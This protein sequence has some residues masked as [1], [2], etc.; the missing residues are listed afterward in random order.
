MFIYI[1]HIYEFRSILYRFHLITVQLI[2]M[3]KKREFILL[4]LGVILT[5]IGDVIGTYH[6]TPNLA[7]E[8]N[9]MVSLLGMG[10]LYILTA[11]VTVI[12]FSATINYYSLFK[13][14]PEE[15][16][17]RDLNLNNYLSTLYF[18]KATEWKWWYA[19]VKRPVGKNQEIYAYGWI[20]PRILIHVGI[21]I[22]IFHCLLAF[23]PGYISIH[24]YFVVPMY[25]LIVLCIPYNFLSYLKFRYKRYLLF[26]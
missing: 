9:P 2:R 15:V 26:R 3:H 20:I 11:Q 16:L 5:R 8:A 7:S 23:V 10:W 13:V 6:Y 24:K 25:L 1:L 14:M 21:I 19:F 22:I 18:S 12:V 17:T 4:L